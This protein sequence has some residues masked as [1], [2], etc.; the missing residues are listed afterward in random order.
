MAS[1]TP[2][3]RQAWVMARASAIV[4]AIGLSRN[5]CLPARAAAEV[6]S[7]WESFGVVLMMPSTLLF[8]RTSWNVRELEHPYFFANA[9]RFS[10]DLEKQ[11]TISSL[12]ERLIASASTS[13]HQPIPMQA[14]F[15]SG[16]YFPL[17]P[18][19]STASRATRSSNSK[20]PPLTP[21]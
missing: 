10:S 1:T 17:A 4:L 2:A 21:M 14:T 15:T 3:L 16:F 11:V 9:D 20:L 6:V 18:I 12:P 7:R 8:S 19:D 5:T 13:D